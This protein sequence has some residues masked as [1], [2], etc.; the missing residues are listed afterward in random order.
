MITENR[1]DSFD[2]NEDS[3]RLDMLE[4]R[5]PV[6]AVWKGRGSYELWLISELLSKIDSLSPANRKILLTRELVLG[7][8]EGE[9]DDL[10]VQD[11]KIAIKKMLLI[12]LENR[13]FIKDLIPDLY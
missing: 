9:G 3:R 5:D 7:L 6:R 13:G 8:D 12:G 1:T 11:S 4:N 10:L 2:I